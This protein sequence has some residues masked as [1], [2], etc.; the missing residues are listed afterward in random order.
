MVSIKEL[1]TIIL[2]DVDGASKICFQLMWNDPCSHNINRHTIYDISFH[3]RLLPSTLPVIANNKIPIAT[4]RY[5]FLP[6]LEND[7][8]KWA[9]A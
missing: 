7:V 6:S 8:S 5:Q 2:K 1:P 4:Y 3:Y 9:Y